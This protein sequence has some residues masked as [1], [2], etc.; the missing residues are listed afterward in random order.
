MSKQYDIKHR[1]DELEQSIQ[2]KTSAVEESSLREKARL[3]NAVEGIITSDDKGLI[4]SFNTMAE[5]MFGYK[6]DEV[7][8]ENPIILMP[9]EEA[10][11]H[12]GFIENYLKTG[13]G[14]ILGVCER[15]LQGRRRDGALIPLE[16]N[17]VEFMLGGERK[18]IGSMRDITQ[19]KKAE[20]EARRAADSQA[21]LQAVAQAASQA[22]PFKVALEAGLAAVCGY[23]GWHVGHV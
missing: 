7:I 15:E 2:E 20:E 12:G 10:G 23:T 6:A 16:L 8:G 22:Q 11:N 18:F 1:P 17:V 21:M 5:R 3:E 9:M 19:R 13:H 14:K 4:E